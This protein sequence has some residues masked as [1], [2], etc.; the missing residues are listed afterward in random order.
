MYRGGDKRQEGFTTS[1]V[2]TSWRVSAGNRTRSLQGHNGFQG[3]SQRA[4][5][6]S[7][8]SSEGA[9]AHYTPSACM[10]LVTVG[11]TVGGGKP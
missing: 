11:V 1:T 5:P 4:C 6:R 3:G 7:Y 8:A 9:A 10:G 2:T